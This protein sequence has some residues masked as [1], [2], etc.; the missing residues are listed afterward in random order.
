MR[1]PNRDES[2]VRPRNYTSDESASVAFEDGT[3]DSWGSASDWS[4]PSA[5][6][7]DLNDRR[8]SDGMD[9]EPDGTEEETFGVGLLHAWV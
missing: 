8:R 5:P 9:Q 4:S 7:P 2:E 1:F 3:G 6:P